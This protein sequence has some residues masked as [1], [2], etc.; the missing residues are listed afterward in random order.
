[1]ANAPQSELH[2][3]FSDPTVAAVCAALFLLIWYR[4]LKSWGR[5]RGVRV[6]PLF[7]LR[8]LGIAAVGGIAAGV[9]SGLGIVRGLTRFV[10][11]D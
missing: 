10:R 1:M 11:S 3:F 2:E 5:R 9:V 7:P 6:T 4:R 8:L